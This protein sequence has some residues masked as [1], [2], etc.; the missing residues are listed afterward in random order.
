MILFNLSIPPG[1]TLYHPSTTYLSCAASTPHLHRLPA[2]HLADMAWALTR[3]RFD[4]GE[5]WWA[6]MRKGMEASMRSG[7]L[8]ARVLAVAIW[9]CSQQGRRPDRSWLLRLRS[10]LAPAAYSS[11]SAAQVLRFIAMAVSRQGLAQQ[12]QQQQQGLRT[13]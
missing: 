5:A 1:P 11:P 7:E 2:P 6:A 12:Q 8:D 10:I 13:V 3:L 4:P 9:A